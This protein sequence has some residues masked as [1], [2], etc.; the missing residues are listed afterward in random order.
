MIGGGAAGS[1]APGGTRVDTRERRARRRRNWMLGNQRQRLEERDRPAVKPHGNRVGNRRDL[2]RLIGIEPEE[3]PIVRKARAGV[4][5]HE[6]EAA[7]HRV[8]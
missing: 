6:V 5:M 2:Q 1:G 3:R 7:R 8:D 4:G